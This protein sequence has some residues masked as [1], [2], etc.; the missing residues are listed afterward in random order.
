MLSSHTE[1]GESHD[2]ALM[3][4]SGLAMSPQKFNSPED[5]LNSNAAGNKK[6]K[7]N[8]SI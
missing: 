2:A 1:V 3:V 5:P 7:S 8:D 6:I 4:Y